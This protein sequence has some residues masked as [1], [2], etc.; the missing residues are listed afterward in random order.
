MVLSFLYLAFRALL[1]AL[2]RS[3]R[4]LDVKDVELLVLRHERDIL[5]RQVA[6][7]KLGV[8]DRALLAA[9]GVLSR[10]SQRVEVALLPVGHST[11]GDHGRGPWSSALSAS[12][13]RFMSLRESATT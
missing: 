3:R 12:D 4:G 8:V 9:A 13:R 10:P 5:S 2:V 7:P 1:G 6:R 11:Q